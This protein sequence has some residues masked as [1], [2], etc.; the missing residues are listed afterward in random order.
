MSAGM[1]VKDHDGKPLTISVFECDGRRVGC[2]LPATPAGEMQIVFVQPPN[3]LVVCMPADRRIDLAMALL[4]ADGMQARVTLTKPSHLCRFCKKP[5]RPVR[6]ES[7]DA[8]V[9]C[10]ASQE[11]DGGGK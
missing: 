8:H 10:A 2:S 4:S 1:Q 7:R 6:G 3:Q 5:V 11:I 9:K